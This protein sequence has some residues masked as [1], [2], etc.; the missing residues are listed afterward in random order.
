MFHALVEQVASTPAAPPPSPAPVVSSSPPIEACMESMYIL[1]PFKEKDAA[2]ALGA[3]WDAD[4]KKWYAPSMETFSKLKKWHPP[5]PPNTVAYDVPPPSARPPSPLIL[6]PALVRM[7]GHQTLS[8]VVVK[9]RLP[10]TNHRFAPYQRRPTRGEKMVCMARSV[11][12]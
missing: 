9:M 12:F 3:K 4:A 8:N 11:S 10:Y 2:K 6:P 5:P 1:C 7:R